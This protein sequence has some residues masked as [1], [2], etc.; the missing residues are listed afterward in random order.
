MATLDRSDVGKLRTRSRPDNFAC[1]VPVEIPLKQSV[2]SVVEFSALLSGRN[3][4]AV[5]TTSDLDVEGLRP[6]LPVLNIAV[7]VD[8][9]DFSAQDVVAAGDL[10][11][12]RDALLVA[13]VIEDGIGPPVA[14]L[15]LLAAVR[16]AAGA[17]VDEGALM[18][19]EE[20]QLSLV[21]VLAVTIAWSEIGGCPTVVRAI[22]AL[23]VAGVTRAGVMP[24][25]SNFLTG[26]CSD[27]IR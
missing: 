3:L 7:V 22:P 25:E 10:L 13:V 18:D 17:V 27:C 14:G 5:I 6:E 1:V 21:D 11:G 2:T 16:V 19:L 9:D 23:L 20:L 12:D 8:G 26:W 15:G 24:G 4:S